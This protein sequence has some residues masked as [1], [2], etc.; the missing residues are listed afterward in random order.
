MS[1]QNPWNVKQVT[2]PDK[3]VGSEGQDNRGHAKFIAPHFAGRAA[4]HLFN[5][6]WH[7]DLDNQR[8]G[9]RTLNGLMGDEERGWC[10]ASDTQGSIPGN[11]QN[12][13][14]QVATFIADHIAFNPDADLPSPTD[15]PALW[16]LI[17]YYL[18][19]TED[20]IY[21]T[22]SLCVASLALF[23]RLDVPTTD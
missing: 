9:L 16:L 19:F 2:P 3:W 17:L 21:P 5:R 23:Y 4:L 22:W 7:D 6:H 12:N 13:P 14:S 11:P 15:D 20:G 18:A 10:P 8:P 1:D